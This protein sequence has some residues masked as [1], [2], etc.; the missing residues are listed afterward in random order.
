[1]G[2]KYLSPKISLKLEG[3]ALVTANRL[4]THMVIIQVMTP[5]G[6]SW[7]PIIDTQMIRSNDNNLPVALYLP[8]NY[9]YTGSSSNSLETKN[10]GPDVKWAD[11][12]GQ[13]L[14][15]VNTKLVSTIYSQVIILPV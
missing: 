4:H 11:G 8:E 14:F 1:V 7:M 10:A 9:M 15:K 5:V 3:L 6:Y 12:K 2:G 13:K